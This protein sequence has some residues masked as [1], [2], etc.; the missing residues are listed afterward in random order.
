MLFEILFQ[1]LHQPSVRAIQTGPEP[2]QVPA[3]HRVY[4]PDGPWQAVS[5][6]LGE[7]GQDLDLYP[8]GL[9]ASTVF[10]Y[11]ICESV[12]RTP[13]GSGGLFNPEDSRTIDDTSIS[14][15]RGTSGLVSEEAS[16]ATILSYANLTF[17]RDQLQISGIT[18][19]NFSVEMYPSITVVYPDGQYPLQ[20]GTLSLGPSVNQ[21]FTQSTGDPAI[22]SS[23]IP[24]DFA[25]Q[26]LI[27]ANSFGLHIGIGVEALEL[28]LSLWLGGYDASRVVGPVSSQSTIN[29]QFVIDLLDIEINVDHGGSPFPFSSQQD[30]LNH[31]DPALAGQSLSVQI[32]PT[33]PYLYLPS[34]TCAAIVKSLPVTY[35]AGKALYLWN[36]ADPQYAKIV[37]SPAYIGF[38]FRGSSGNLTINAPF[39]LFNLTLQAP[40]MTTD[41]PYF[42]CQ[43]PQGSDG[44]YSLGRAFLQAAFI[45]VSWDSTGGEGEWFLAQAPGPNVDATP[46]SKPLTGSPPSG[47]LTKKWADTWSGFW[48]A[49]PT[50]TKTPPPTNIPRTTATAPIS[51]RSL[52]DSAPEPSTLPTSQHK[53]NPPSGAAIAGIVIGTACTTS[54]AIGIGILLSRRR[55]KKKRVALTLS[56][57][58]NM[59][60]HRP[61][62][63]E[64][65]YELP[66][67]WE[68][69]TANEGTG[70]PRMGVLVPELAGD[71]YP[72]FELASCGS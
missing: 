58:P 62:T 65:A 36:I 71:E 26:G 37:K 28:D 19:A 9:Y 72:I 7:P 64:A 32:N 44:H 23:L 50:F 16:G 1:L 41:T 24:G 13:C 8:G 27:P 31:S 45:G 66:Q 18:V 17:V 12:D 20:V 67:D 70:R 69:G 6:R 5:I 48:T 54:V 34:L 11:Q 47:L 33:A 30:L 46:Q 57:P 2:L 29:Q 53:S 25:A 39:Q 4:G 59:M 40:L 68:R 49:V 14:F 3:S 35:D 55:T 42:P 43:P 15:A 63:Q 52:S 22:N 51:S 38:I 60:D 56:P 61:E 10:T 21:S